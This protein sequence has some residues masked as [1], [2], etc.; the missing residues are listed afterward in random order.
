MFTI[1]QQVLRL[2]LYSITLCGLTPTMLAMAAPPKQTPEQPNVVLIFID[3]MGYGDIGPFGGSH[4]TPHLD[5]MAAEGMKLAD[6]YVSASACTPSRASLLTGCYADRIG[7]GDSVVFPGDARGM[8]PSEMTIAEVLKEAGYVTGCF[9]K[10]HLGDQPECMPNAQGFDEYEG[11]PYSNDMWVAGN[12]KKRK[13][14]PLPY[15]IQGEVVAHIP[16][17]ASQ[18]VLTDALSDATV[19][20]MIRHKNRPFFAYVPLAAVHTPWFATEERLKAAGGSA[21]KA[22][23]S[24]VDALVGR[25]M[26]TLI[27]LGIADNT[28]VFFTNDNGG[29]GKSD[30]GILRGGKFSPKY[31]GHMRVP[32]LAWW[33]GSV[34]A[35]AVLKEIGATIDLLPTF[36]KLA[37]GEVPTDR[38]IDGSD[39]SDL[40]LGMPGAK[41]PH[42]N[43]FYEFEGLRQGDWKLVCHRKNFGTQTQRDMR[44]VNELYNLAEDIGEQTNL[45]TQY[46]E[47]VETMLSVLQAHK[48]RVKGSLRPAAF[49]HNPTA[50]L[51]DTADLPTLL[52]YHQ[53]K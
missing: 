27:A 4:P 14:P 31:E 26:D 32:T 36:A 23:I 29:T 10:W 5:R 35:G 47:K 19:D 1:P 44:M 34:P 33:P 24:E 22:Q 2:C 45:A 20:F 6:F 30:L 37:G 11:I 40:L 48:T 9:G 21:Y 13:F 41:S 16:D 17:E 49:A 50:I 7:M 51:S 18:A 3:D 43:L 25:V 42:A 39:I 53:N 46:P 12:P 15:M 28:L 8:N 38:I 52:N